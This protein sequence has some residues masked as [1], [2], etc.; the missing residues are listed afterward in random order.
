M[1]ILACAG[2]NGDEDALKRLVSLAERKKPHGILFAGGIMNPASGLSRAEEFLGTFFGSV[3]KASN[4]VAIIPGP[5]DVP[6]YR[7]LHIATNAEI[8]TPNLFIAHATP[9]YSGD[10]AVAG[11]GGLITETDDAYEPVLKYSRPS[12]LYFLRALWK[13]NKPI[14][15]LLLSEPPPELAGG[16]G[17]RIVMEFTKSYHPYF[18]IVMGNKQ[19]RGSFKVDPHSFI[20]N[21]GLVTE[22]SAALI[23]TV[24]RSADM[25]D[26]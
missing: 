24:Q 7:F 14:R 16:Q 3:S 25:L 10:V 15:I 11:I 6:L 21:P 26:F 2:V 23:D 8:S 22:G 13:A 12:A 17:N 1:Q 20:I 5:S 4:F 19:F 9:V 18:C